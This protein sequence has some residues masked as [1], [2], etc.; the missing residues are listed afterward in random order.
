LAL[1]KV[2]KPWRFDFRKNSQNKSECDTPM[3]LG[4]AVA[5]LNAY[6]KGVSLGLFE[7]SPKKIDEH[8]E[9]A[10]A[11]AALKVALLHRAVP[12]VR[13][14]EGL[15]ALSRDRPISSANVDRCLRGKFGE[16][17][18]PALHAMEK[19]ARSLAP[20]EQLG[21]HYHVYEAL[22]RAGCEDGARRES[23]I[24]TE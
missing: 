16:D 23:L 8:L 19:L 18:D 14:P 3:T 13:T 17:F 15:R 11:G 4:C 9:K 20:R 12:L 24:P 1:Q 7:P 21:V 2:T 22:S 10:E 6:A 5:A